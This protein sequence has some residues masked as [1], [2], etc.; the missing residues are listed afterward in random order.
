MTPLRALILRIIRTGA[1]RRALRISIRRLH[2]RLLLKYMSVITSKTWSICL[3]NFS[4]LRPSFRWKNDSAPEAQ[5]L[6]RHRL[7]FESALHLLLV[8]LLHQLSSSAIVV[9]SHRLLP[10]SNA[11]L[12]FSNRFQ[13]FQWEI[14]VEQ[15]HDKRRHLAIKN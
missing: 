13:R 1:R 15:R 4:T 8:L 7:R 9:S 12:L 5:P 10:S 14:L 2:D 11:H 3:S 6:C